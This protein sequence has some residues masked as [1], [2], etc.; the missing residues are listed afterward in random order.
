MEGGQL[1]SELELIQELVAIIIASRQE[2]DS[3]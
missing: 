3:R 2:E 1:L